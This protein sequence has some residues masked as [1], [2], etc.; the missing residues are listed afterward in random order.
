M[1]W[2]EHLCAATALFY[3]GRIAS[4]GPGWL[5][6]PVVSDAGEEPRVSIVVPARNEA[7]NIERCLRSLAAQSH[8]ACEIIVVDDRS[9]D[10]TWQII[11]RFAR[12]EPRVRAVAG[13]PLPEGWVGKP[14]ALHQGAALARAEWLLFTDAD[15]CHFPWA[16]GSALRLAAAR[17][18]D[19]LSIGTYQE[20]HTFWERAA[21]PSILGMVLFA[22]GTFTELNDPRKPE[23]ALANGQY[24]LIRRAAYDALGGHERLRA[25]IAE[26]LEFARL[27]KRDGRFRLL[28][29]SGE[30]LVSV[31]MYRSL[32]GIWEGFTK[33]VY[34]GASGNALQLLAGTAF[35]CGISVVP[36]LLALRAVL[37][38][39]P[40]DALEALAASAACI[41]AASWAVGKTRLPRRLGFYQPLGTALLAAITLNSILC[42]LSGRGV[43]WRGRSYSGR[44]APLLEGTQGPS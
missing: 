7:A 34:L 5:R 42:V 35:L 3:A 21:L 27:L 38:K 11:E 39:R 8:R 14:W 36:P 30:D 4:F 16:L 37:R 18:V 20:L 13:E 6:V 10:A 26:D 43:S 2:A 1:G 23:R 44:V 24:I 31:R 25:Q 17:G 40:L 22:S 41:G 15:T 19:A 32:R 33:N 12:S 29:A 9:S 28:L